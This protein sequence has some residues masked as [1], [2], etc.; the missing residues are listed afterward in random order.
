MQ[1]NLYPPQITGRS[2]S[3]RPTLAIASAGKAPVGKSGLG[4]LGI[5]ISE[6]R[7]PPRT[8]GMMSLKAG[9]VVLATRICRKF[10]ITSSRPMRMAKLRNSLCFQ[11]QQIG[12]LSTSNLDAKI[13][14][15]VL[16][17]NHD[18]LPEPSAILES[19]VSE[20]VNKLVAS[21]LDHGEAT[22]S[23]RWLVEELRP[24]GMRKRSDLDVD[25]SS[26]ASSN[27]SSSSNLS[28]TAS[29]DWKD[30]LREWVE[31]RAKREPVQYI[32]GKWPFYPL[33]ELIVRPPILIPR[34]ETEE[35]VD[36]ICRSY[37]ASSGPIRLVDFGSGSG[38][39]CLALLHSFPKARAVAV[40]PSPFAVE[41]TKEN[42]EHC[43]LS[44]RLDVC[45]LRAQDWALQQQE[46]LFDLIVSNPPYIPSG[47]LPDLQVEV[48]DFE[49]P[50]A[51]DGGTDG[52]DIIIE[53]L[54]CARQVGRPGARIFLE[55][56]HTHPAI[57]EAAELHKV[58][59]AA[60][61]DCSLE[62]SSVKRLAV[63]LRGL[64]LSRSIDDL[65]GQPRFVELELMGSR[66]KQSEQ[67]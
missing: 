31:R 27:A 14:R 1:V 54:D 45:N 18:E 12:T 36:I 3:Q 42:S 23:V 41:L 55:V 66:S 29:N 58:A 2:F 67:N 43:G 8:V 57:F 10:G 51:L 4:R 16:S 15:Q 30:T 5:G 34:P 9:C 7:L 62:M 6:G 63:A 24:K 21:G 49:D 56:H 38:A 37:G 22:A 53:V 47:E 59:S 20:S 26:S 25:K 40:D 44:D 48:R 61:A 64:K 39:I 19:V 65:Y 52:L 35:L 60:E 50:G 11:K 33:K 32:I 17:E 46:N 13:V 28:S